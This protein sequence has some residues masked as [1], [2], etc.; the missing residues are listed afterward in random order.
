M[1]YPKLD[2]PE[3]PVTGRVHTYMAPIWASKLKKDTMK[4]KQISERGGV[5]TVRLADNRVYISG[6]VQLFMEGEIPFDL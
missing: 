3:D 4:A 6:N 1:L 2:V 5:L